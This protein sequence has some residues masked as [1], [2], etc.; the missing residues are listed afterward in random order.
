MTVRT[1]CRSYAHP[2]LFF[3]A[4]TNFGPGPWQHLTSLRPSQLLG[5]ANHV[6]I[7]QGTL[8]RSSHTNPSSKVQLEV[9]VVSHGAGPTVAPYKAH[10]VTLSNDGFSSG[11]MAGLP[12]FI[13]HRLGA[14]NV[15]PVDVYARTVHHQHTAAATPVGDAVGMIEN[16][17]VT[18]FDLQAL[19][20]ESIPWSHT[21]GTS[22][23]QFATP[24][25]SP[26]AV[27]TSP[28]LTL[29]SP[30]DDGTDVWALFWD[31]EVIPREPGQTWESRGPSPSLTFYGP[32]TVNQWRCV[33][34]VVQSGGTVRSQWVGH[35][36]GSRQTPTVASDRVHVGGSFLHQFPSGQT[37]DRFE[38]YGIEDTNWGE[39]D[40]GAGV[41]QTTT[42]TS[43]VAF[44]LFAIP[45]HKLNLQW[46][47]NASST[48]HYGAPD[49]HALEFP[50]TEVAPIRVSWT[51]DQS[52][53]RVAFFN[54]VGRPLFNQTGID[55]E[56]ATDV[57]Y[58]F[59]RSGTIGTNDNPTLYLHHYDETEHT[60]DNEV[61]EITEIV[62]PNSIQGTG[63]WNPAMAPVFRQVGGADYAAT[64]SA[65]LW[66]IEQ[67]VG[68]PTYTE[69]NPQPGAD[70]YLVPGHEAPDVAN[71]AAL[72]L[73]P[74]NLVAYELDA[75]PSALRTLD[76][77]LITWPRYLR[78]KV[79]ASF[80][81]VI[82]IA[83]AA[84]ATDL[85]TLTTFIRTTKAFQF[86]PYGEPTARPYVI[87][88]ASVQGPKQVSRKVVEMQFDA[89][90]LRYVGP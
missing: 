77:E 85:S 76:G 4:S 22:T 60:F 16:L 57:E 66:T 69:P 12:F 51:G 63:K 31:V 83:N 20:D 41:P 88:R 87:D 55:I 84:G 38:V 36:Y 32:F 70:V 74:T 7:V 48:A 39:A 72:P 19:D 24:G 17:T 68:I 8:A 37:T 27:L 81:F 65:Q 75:E 79:R 47:E 9:R 11:G 28:G 30:D 50:S 89:F 29:T 78:P 49:E 43:S 58:S 10:H 40:G 71:L 42:R 54:G 26:G 34:A 18:F 14:S 56:L 15:N 59:A 46:T 33:P 80:S 64:R 62:G 1:V 67:K 25:S 86:A 53:G 2:L 21:S 61:A 3:S 6:A 5:N 52:R 45:A 73:T 13:V 44:E 82:D 90:E 23:V 35:G